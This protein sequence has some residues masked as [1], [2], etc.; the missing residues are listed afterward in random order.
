MFSQG[1]R[2]VIYRVPD[3]ARAK[4]WYSAAFGVL[5]YFDEPFYVGFNIGGYELG[6]QPDRSGVVVG[7]NVEA[8]WGVDNADQAYQDL[9]EKG[10]REHSPVTA[11]GGGIRVATLA[12]PFGNIIGLIENPHFQVQPA[13]PASAPDFTA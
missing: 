8:Y 1:L 10:A 4:A 2:T 12:D 9:L 7:T 6:L 3:L 11:V 13:T 5:P